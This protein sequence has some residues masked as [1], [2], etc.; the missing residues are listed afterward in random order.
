[1]KEK[2]TFYKVPENYN[3]KRP[4]TV[5][6]TQSIIIIFALLFLFILLLNFVMSLR[7]LDQEF[8]VV[9]TIVGYSVTVGFIILL[10]VAFYGLVKRA[11]YGKSG[12]T[13]KS[14]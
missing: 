7:H 11:T 4:P 2:P 12:L 5:W 8:S 13:L 1:M 9:R 6:L 10:V 14:S 3:R